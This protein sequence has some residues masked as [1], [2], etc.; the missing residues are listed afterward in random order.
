MVYE[1]HHRLIL[2]YV[3]GSHDS[4]RILSSQIRDMTSGRRETLQSLHEAK[5]LAV[6]MKAALVTGNLDDF[7]LLLDRAWESKKRFTEAYEPKDRCLVKG[8][9]Q[10][11]PWAGRSQER[12]VEGLCSSSQRPTRGMP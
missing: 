3:G 8:L 2:A 6:A 12:V 10:P 9:N 1:L 5:E 7:G 11:V 4:S